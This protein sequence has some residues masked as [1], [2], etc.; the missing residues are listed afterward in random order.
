MVRDRL[1]TELI[2]ALSHGS[3]DIG[4]G[5]VL[6]F[7]SRAMY[8]GEFTVGD[9]A[10]FAAYLWP[11]TQL[12]RMVG[13]VFTL[14]RQSGVSLQRMEK[15]MQGSPP[16]G[17][18]A[19]H[20]I[21]L[22]G[23]YPE[24][25]YTPKLADHHLDRLRVRGLTFQYDGAEGE[26]GIYD[27]DLEIK[28]GTLTVITGRVGSGKTTLLKVL[29]GLLPS[30][31]GEI[32]WNGAVVSDPGDFLIPPRCAYTGQ[33][34]RL[35]SDSLFNNI[36]MGLP[37]DRVDLPAAIQS[38]VF[39]EDLLTMEQGL[40]TLIG[41]RGQRLSGGQIQR[42]AA[43]RMFVRQ[44]ELMVFDDLSSA[45]DVETETLLWQRLFENRPDTTDIPTSLVVSHRRAVLRQADQVI[46]LKDGR[47]LDQGTLQ[48]L[49]QRCGEMRR[50]WEGDEADT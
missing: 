8:A 10:L 23:P 20:P 44:A 28:R 24:I 49:L 45:L 30:Q 35:F 47:I 37:D 31:A 25:P 50:L 9:F 6:L 19:H 4:M 43:A 14:Y 5:F 26:A 36:L 17:P 39:E 22:S 18:V 38:A 13:H 27:I 48:D 12:F 46:V 33:V 34:P 11:M 7:A 15:M 42:T 16:G 32:Y 41:P 40:D 29:L 21:Y 1:L 2:N 3:M